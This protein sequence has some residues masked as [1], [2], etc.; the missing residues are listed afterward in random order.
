VRDI[1]DRK[2][3]IPLVDLQVGD[4]WGIGTPVAVAHEIGHGS[5]HFD[6]VIGNGAKIAATQIGG[7]PAGLQAYWRRLDLF[8]SIDQDCID[9]RAHRSIDP[10]STAWP[11]AALL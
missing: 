11:L 6:T 4:L 3:I 9:S 7:Q 1:A 10:I 2:S 5:Q 8:C